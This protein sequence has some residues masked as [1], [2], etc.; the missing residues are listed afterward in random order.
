MAQGV[1]TNW[2]GP[3]FG[4]VGAG[5]S[6][7][8]TQTDPGIPVA[9]TTGPTGPTGCT[10]PCADG[11]FN[12]SGGLIGGGLG[13][14]WQVANWVIGLAGDFSGG[15]VSGSSNVCGATT[16]TPYPCGTSFDLLGTVRGQI[17][18]AIGPT[19]NWL[20]YITGG[21]AFGNVHAWDALTPA[22]GTVTRTGWTLGAG[23]AWMVVP[24]VSV[25]FE[26]LH[27]DLGSANIFNVVP[28]NS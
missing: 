1:R 10:G 23:I 11:H 16:P 6:G 4:V 18:S 15:N 27:V 28:G 12:M 22:A 8:S 20:P 3:T 19:G 9:G 24:N 14:N 17:G 7:S 13:Y 5:A 25:K 21:L 2:S 26:Y